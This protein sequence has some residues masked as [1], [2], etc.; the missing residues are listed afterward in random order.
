MTTT[1][2]AKDGKFTSSRNAQ[3]AVRDGE[4]LKVVRQLRRL[5]RQKKESSRDRTLKIILQANLAKM[6]ATLNGDLSAPGF[7]NVSDLFGP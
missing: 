7:I 4:R 1:Y 3:T 5:R 6:K 2:H